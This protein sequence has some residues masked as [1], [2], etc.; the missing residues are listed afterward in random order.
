MGAGSGVWDVRCG[1]WG[2]GSGLERG[3]SF[4]IVLEKYWKVAH[5][6]AK[7]SLSNCQISKKLLTKCQRL[8]PEFLDILM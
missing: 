2:V 7:L 1:E 6:N 4:L 5:W 3:G 8:L